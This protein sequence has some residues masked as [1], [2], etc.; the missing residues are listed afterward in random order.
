MKIPAAKQIAARIKRFNFQK[1]RKYEHFDMFAGS[2]AALAVIVIG[3]IFLIATH[4]ATSTTAVEPELGT[5]SG[6]ASIINDSSASGG[7]Y[8][9]FGSQNQTP[10]PPASNVSSSN[11]CP[12]NAAPA[13]W[14]HVVVLIFENKGYS[15]VIGSGQSPYITSLA[16]KCGTYKNW[17]DAD[18][19]VDGTKDRS[20]DY[21][22]KPNYATY[23]SGV[24]P[25]VSKIT[26]DD[27]STTTGVDN[28]F[29]RLRQAGISTKSYQPGPAGQCSK[30]NYNGAY[31]DAMRY[32]TDVGG[33][34][35]DPTT[36]CNQHDV[37][38]GDFMTDVN[39][40]KLPAFSVVYPTNDQNTH[41]NSISSG[42]TWAKNFLTPFFDSDQYKSG[43]T[44]LFFVWDEDTPI[45]NVLAA[46]SVKP[47]SSPTIPSG[48]YPISHFSALRTWQE[49][50]GLSPFLGNSG[51]APSLLSFYNGK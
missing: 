44:A 38:I 1:I 13:K 51:Q 50:L 48:S 41:D 27:F 2:A 26:T 39:S 6:N 20:T 10:P 5:K 32:F 22:S 11:P 21:N 3:S 34:S 28:I 12:G 25:S 49:M 17:K 36:F 4:A 40:G 14:N 35:S 9:V 24:S 45:P 29:N 30:D 31:H 8:I 33:Q 43:D 37:N 42:D 46:P 47:G 16:A 7:K 23:M 19:R 15:D 18:Y